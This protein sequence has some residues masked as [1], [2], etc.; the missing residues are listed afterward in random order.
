MVLRCIWK[1]VCA[2]VV[3][4][5][6]WRLA[7]PRVKSTKAFCII[8]TRVAMRLCICLTPQCCV[9]HDILPI[10]DSRDNAKCS[11]CPSRYD[12]HKCTASGNGTTCASASVS[13]L[14]RPEGC[15]RRCVPQRAPVRLSSPQ[16]QLPRPRYPLQD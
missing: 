8:I 9:K 11:A 3:L 5:E 1:L 16:E 7:R 12:L 10:V 4:H 15:G 14:E 2:F 6:C 13:L